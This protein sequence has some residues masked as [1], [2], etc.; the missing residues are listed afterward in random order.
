MTFVDML[1]YLRRQA[2]KM[3]SC[4]MIGAAAVDCKDSILLLEQGMGGTVPF[5]PVAVDG[6]LH[7]PDKGD[8]VIP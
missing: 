6:L 2:G 4:C 1:P 3:T 5:P 8:K 7:Y